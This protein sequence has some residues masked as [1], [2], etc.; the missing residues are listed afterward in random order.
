MKKILILT[1]L[2]FALT[3][4]S[5]KKSSALPGALV[6]CWSASYEENKETS[7]EKIYRSCDHEFPA[8]RFRQSIVFEKNGT[9]K[10]LHIGEADAH[11]YVDCKYVYDKKKKTID[12]SD[13]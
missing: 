7:K 11:Y 3:A 1:N 5:Q 8:S 4:F 12:I 2:L 9:C 13:D 6:K 10:V